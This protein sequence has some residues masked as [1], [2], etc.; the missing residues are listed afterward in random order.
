MTSTG[1]TG[2]QLGDGPLCERE[3]ALRLVAAEARRARSGS[4]RLVLLRGATGTGRSA[5]LEAVA[6]DGTAQGMRVL[7]ARCSTERSG[8]EYGAL[9]HLLVG[10][11]RA[12]T[13][14]NPVNG[15][16]VADQL[17]QLV[18]S[19]AA[20]MP[21]LLAIDDVHLADP[22][23]R[24]F[25]TEAARQLDTLPVLIVVT[26]R[27][28]YDIA[29][30]VPG[31]AHTLSPTLVRGHVLGPLSRAA[32]EA[33]VHGRLGGRAT[34]AW[35]DGCLHASA[36]NPLLLRALLDDL[37]V[38]F[39]TPPADRAIAA[40]LP[41]D[42]PD[43]TQDSPDFAQDWPA[44][45]QTCADLYPGAFAAAVTWWLESAG[46]ETAAV[47]RRLADVVGPA[48]DAA[49]PQ[50]PLPEGMSDDVDLVAGV[51]GTDPSR[52][53]GWMTAMLRLGLLRET[54]GRVRFAHP[55]LRDAVLDGWQ[56]A[57][58]QA[59]HRDAAAYRQRR[60]DPTE[61]VAAHLLRTHAVGAVW[62]V[63]VLRDAAATAARAG[64]TTDAV[65][66]LRRA[67][68]E[69]V[70]RVR[71]A[72]VLTELASLELASLRGT[73]IPRLAEALRLREEPRER[74]QATV[75]LGLAMARRGEAQAAVALLQDLDAG[76]S[77]TDQPALA[78]TVRLASALLSDHD[79]EV[80][81]EVYDEL[82]ESADRDPALFGPAEQALLVRHETTAGLLSADEAMRRLRAL[83][84]ADEDP[85]L[86][87]YLLGT[88]AAV[89]QW[90]DALDDADRLVRQGLSTHR[91]PPLHP[92]HQALLNTRWDVMAARGDH[93]RLLA[94][95]ERREG[96]T[97]GRAVRPGNLLAHVVIALVETGR[98]D[99]AARLTASVDV[100]ISHVPDDTW[101]FN[102]FLYARGVV[103][104][105]SGEFQEAVDD[106]L[107]CGRRQTSREV[108]SPVVTPWRSA[109]AEC[110]L[111]LGSPQ[112]ALPLAE[113]EFR[114]ASVWGTPRV[115]GRALRVLGAVSNG[116]RGLELTARAVET[117]RGGDADAELAAALIAQ[118]RRLTA[119][120][121]RLQ[122]RA[123]LREA[124]AVAERLGSARLLDQA[125]Q[126]L[127]TGSPRLR[128]TH[129]SG[130]DALTESE[131]R[132][133]RL[134]ADGRTNAEISALLHLARRTVE[135]HLTSTYR[136]LAIRGRNE[137]P[138][139]LDSTPPS[140]LSLRA[141][142]PS[143]PDPDPRPTAGPQIPYQLRREAPTP[144][145]IHGEAQ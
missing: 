20:G 57:D 77:L 7:R 53:A 74:V 3:D 64:R 40:G 61:A 12:D 110:L 46:P 10:E 101:E 69:P 16:A 105:A 31:L 56:R 99:E 85:L 5:L 30:P 145:E 23:S 95:F 84:S 100:Q 32:A 28:Q 124:T 68:E 116:R 143:G 134:A 96:G 76:G 90:A 125:E 80:R 122:A 54:R 21:L 118:G 128:V 144:Q 132:I 121:Q 25:L 62:A 141:V 91:L 119:A 60:G 87:P 45:P 108:V 14:L 107:E 34:D 82:H 38:A 19:A 58:R 2:R 140:R 97:S 142:R 15:T 127:R 8:T 81:R 33:M 129:H 130:V 123:L 66:L 51:T 103:R 55:L 13:T 79:R 18:R 72:E 112:S 136:K 26:E 120:G 37:D 29:A 89:A 24:R 75:A 50:L 117:L 98:L 71:R 78:R 102:R 9:R 4:G 63:D 70:P 44:F 36:G 11:Q 1:S 94:E 59:A 88:A 47:A 109:A 126:A 133:A 22:A 83:L 114:L 6:A 27:G 65:T 106:F 137:L 111:A 139:A 48:T 115:L 93:A 39:T 17:W 135:T 113:E 131:L 35:V 67:L 73:G 49:A 138:S 41:Q 104:A 86:M 43:F 92:M 42:S 52:V